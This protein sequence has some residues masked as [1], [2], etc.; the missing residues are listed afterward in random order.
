MFKNYICVSCTCDHAGENKDKTLNGVMAMSIS[1]E[2]TYEHI[3]EK[4]AE[5]I[6]EKYNVKVDPSDIALTGI[7]EISKRLFKRLK[8]K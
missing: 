5:Y 8:D 1:G 7:S 4:M 3:R 6:L 2:T